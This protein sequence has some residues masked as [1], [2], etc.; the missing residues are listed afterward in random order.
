[1]EGW[2]YGKGLIYLKWCFLAGDSISL[3]M[4]SVGLKAP[5]IDPRGDGLGKKLCTPFPLETIG[6]DYISLTT[7]IR[8]NF[9]DF[10]R[11]S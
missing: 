2:Q 7:L 9:S 1:M 5:L 4:D 11:A 8:G 6:D 10:V 3:D